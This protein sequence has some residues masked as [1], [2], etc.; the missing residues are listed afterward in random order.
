M[1]PAR[2]MFHNSRRHLHP[3]EEGLVSAVP[4]MEILK[5]LQ[6]KAEALLSFPEFLCGHYLLESSGKG[7]KSKRHLQ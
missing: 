7:S 4:L 5:Q 3:F 6:M 2:V 1:K